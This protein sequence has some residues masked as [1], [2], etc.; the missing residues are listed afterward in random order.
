MVNVSSVV[1]NVKSL[2]ITPRLFLYP[3]HVMLKGIVGSVG[4]V[5]LVQGFL[6]SIRFSIP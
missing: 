6:P 2:G 1:F 4:R 3:L 5:P